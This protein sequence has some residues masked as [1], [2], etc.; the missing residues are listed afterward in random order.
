MSERELEEE[1]ADMQH[2]AKIKALEEEILLLR[3]RAEEAEL[4]LEDC[5]QSCDDPAPAAPPPPPPPPPP[6]GLAAPPP[7][8]PPPS[9]ALNGGGG[10]G[11]S[12]Q[13]AMGG[14]KK[15]NRQTLDTSPNGSIGGD[16][17]LVSAV[18]QIDDIV[19]QLKQGIKLRHID[20][21]VQRKVIRSNQLKIICSKSKP[22]LFIIC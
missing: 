14:L 7:P 4:K 3:Q 10:L 6:M 19:S 20:R 9:F 15:G 11:N 18:P 16:K 12:L 8:P 2:N 21:T 1:T 13:A 17:N 5:P 22:G